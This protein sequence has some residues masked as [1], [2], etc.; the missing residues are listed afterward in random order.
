MLHHVKNVVRGKFSNPK[1]NPNVM[2]VQLGLYLQ[3]VCHVQPARKEH[4]AINLVYWNVFHVAMER[5][6]VQKVN[7]IALNAHLVS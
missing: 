7:Q 3:E 2:Y 5:T 4:T 1:V 6:R